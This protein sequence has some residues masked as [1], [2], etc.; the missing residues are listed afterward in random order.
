MGGGGSGHF[1][2]R[3]TLNLSSSTIGTLMYQSHLIN[4]PV[5]CIMSFLPLREVQMVT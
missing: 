4:L 5:S 2:E 3:G 1:L